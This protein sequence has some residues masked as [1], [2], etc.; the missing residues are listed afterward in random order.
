MPEKA[1]LEVEARVAWIHMLTYSRTS[2][3]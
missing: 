3:L 1:A 2:P